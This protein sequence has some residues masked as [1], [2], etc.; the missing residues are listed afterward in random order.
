MID[1]KTDTIEHKKN[2][3]DGVIVVNAD[4]PEEA[5]WY[6]V[7]TY[8]GHEN[9]VAIT[10]KQR[11]EA[12]GFT[13]RIFKMFIPQQQKIVVS[14]GKKRSTD[15]K[16]FPGYMIVQMLMDDDT[17]YI[18]RS[19]PGVTGFVGMGSTPTPLPEPEVRTLMK[20]AKME[21]P[22]FE[23]KF[24][25]GDSV[26]I[27]DGPFRDFL[28]KVDEVNDDQGKVKVLVSVFGRETP[29]ELDFTQISRI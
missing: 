19:T 22:K 12:A 1:K 17:W 8:S 5:K 6:V 18:V 15:E 11:A 9:K 10:L 2:Q 28:G 20:F 24:Q 29:V 23:A 4:V 7:H 25:V 16:L 21:A 13:N 27:A 14:E 3:E 26:K